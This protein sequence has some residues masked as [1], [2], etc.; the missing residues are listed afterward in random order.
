MSLSPHVP[1]RR[2]V[3][4]W[5]AIPWV[6]GAVGPPL[7]AFTV[8]LGS[9]EALVRW[10]DVSRLV[11]PPPSAIAG[12]IVSDW[13]GWL[14][15]A[16]VTAQEAFVG[17]ALALVIALVLAVAATA[18]ETVERAVLPVVSVVQLVPVVAL[19]PALVIGLGF[20]MT[21]RVLVA[22]LITFAPLTVNAIVGLQAVDPDALEVL[23]SVNAS[24]AE[25][26]VRLRIPHAL[27]YL[28][29]ATR[30]CVG[31]SLIGAMVAEWQGS[32]EGLGY[33]F[34]RSQRALATDRMWAAV[35]VLALMGVAGT[36]VVGW[37]ERRL[38][39]WRPSRLRH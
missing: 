30:V 23:R 1:P 36:A 22:A 8:L 14:A 20:G 26:L 6:R 28:A 24:R 29:A 13:Q 34:T 2:R 12:A 19:A 3:P 10:R 17:F 9:W 11:L 31:L 37:L 16:W 5:D 15:S 39:R 32:S 25:I 21:P 35:T 33:A 27:P 7:L 38:L 4:A 18:A